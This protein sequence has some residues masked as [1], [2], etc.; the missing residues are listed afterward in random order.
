MMRIF[1]TL[2]SAIML[3][4]SCSLKRDNEGDK[5]IYVT[6]TPLKAIIDELTCGDFTVEVIVPDGA[7]PETY[8]PTPKQLAKI[9]ESRLIFS[10]G[11]IG[12]EQSI[13]EKIENKSKV[14]D[15]SDGI[16]LIE[17]SCSHGH[18]HSHG[19]DPHIWTSPK[20]LRIMVE[21]ARD[22]L[23]RE[24]PDRKEYAEAADRM[25]QRIDALDKECQQQIEQS[26]A[27]AIMIYHPAYTY[28]ARDY[29]IEQ[30]AIEH[31][32]KEPTRKQLTA[33][34]N[35]GERLGIDV[36]FHQPQ[37][38]ADKVRSIA[39]EIGARVV[40]TDPLSADIFAEIERVTEIICKGNE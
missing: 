16:S 11:L 10:T 12:F 15:L 13:V 21:N 3:L 34:C 29:G 23:I 8:E 9:N 14:I 24:F 19:V 27:K 40:E 5:T 4:S 31:D 26:G 30:I 17:G 20:S 32:G 18:H 22:I 35:K 2:I 39:D 37:Y 36:I 38:S 7:S 25:L 33:L 6:I 1:F 28:Y